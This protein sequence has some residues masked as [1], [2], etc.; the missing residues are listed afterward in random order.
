MLSAPSPP[1]NMAK[2]LSVR[3]SRPKTARGRYLDQPLV[4]LVL[5]I[6]LSHS[7]AHPS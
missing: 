5:G 3:S 6:L 2:A 7:P 1:Y 4:K